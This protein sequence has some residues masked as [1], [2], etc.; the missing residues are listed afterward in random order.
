MR[1]LGEPR[2]SR[3]SRRARSGSSVITTCSSPTRRSAPSVK[4]TDRYVTDR[5]RPDK[6]I[7]A[8]DEACAHMQADREVLAAHRGAD[9]AAD[10]SAQAGRGATDKRADRAARDRDGR[11]AQTR[12]TR[13]SA[14]A[15][16]SR[17]CSSAR[18]RPSTA[19]RRTRPNG[20]A[21]TVAVVPHARPARG[22]ARA[23]ADGRGRSSFAATTSRASSG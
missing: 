2:R 11:R 14:S 22:G 3:S 21:E 4:L 16:S 8:L 5:M 12:A 6:A 18:R 7:D 15:P 1:E 10:R 9:R 20:A 13:S 17:R 23:P 19:A